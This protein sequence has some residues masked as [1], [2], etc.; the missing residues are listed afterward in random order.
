MQRD[1]AVDVLA[2]ITG[3]DHPVGVAEEVDAAF[4][5]VLL[6]QGRCGRLGADAGAFDQQHVDTT[7]RI[8]DEAIEQRRL[9][10]SGRGCHPSR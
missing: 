2:G 5:Y 6:R 9:A 10:S 8:G 4:L 3:E 7:R 1:H